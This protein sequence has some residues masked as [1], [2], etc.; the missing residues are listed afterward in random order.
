MEAI[1]GRFQI[2]WSKESLD[3]VTRTDVK[4][5]NAEIHSQSAVEGVLELKHEHQI[6]GAEVKRIDIEIFDVAYKII[7]GGEEGDKTVVRTKEQADHSLPYIVAA[8]LLDDQVMPDQYLPERIQRADVQRLLRKV[9]VRP[10][11]ALSRRFPKEMPCRITIQLQDGRN[12][13]KEKQAYEGFH[14]R[15]V[16]WET[17]VE[18]FERLSHRLAD[19]ALREKLIHGV[20]RL[21][22]ISVAD[23][24]ALLVRLRA[25]ST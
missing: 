11:P 23:L 8:A 19:P 15:P 10:S 3:L 1:A 16:S 20:A 5:Y 14:T 7:G 9:Q 4:K 18:K 13:V 2:D 12:L 17:V 6:A 21:E 22:T 25:D 24:S